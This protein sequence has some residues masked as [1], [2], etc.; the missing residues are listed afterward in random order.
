VECKDID[1]LI[2]EIRKKVVRGA[3]PTRVGRLR[4]C[5]RVLDPQ[6]ASDVGKS[7]LDEATSEDTMTLGDAISRFRQIDEANIPAPAVSRKTPDGS[8]K[9]SKSKFDGDSGAKKTYTG[10]NAP[11]PADAPAKAAGVNTTQGVSGG[12]DASGREKIDVRHEDERRRHERYGVDNYAHNDPNG[13][14]AFAEAMLGDSVG[15]FPS[16]DKI[17]REANL[18]A[19]SVSRKT[20]DGK[21]QTSSKSRFN[22]PYKGAKK[23]Y[24]GSAASVP[25]DQEPDGPGASGREEVDTRYE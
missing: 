11:I 14:V 2:G 20:P 25:S 17:L 7:A 21:S 16:M 4:T 5:L 8:Q 22:E 24:D 3:K 12:Y 13:D 9:S 23:T 10:K 1:Y 18:A 15:Y 19:P 6:Q